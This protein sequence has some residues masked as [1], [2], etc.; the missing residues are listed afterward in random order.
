MVM[1]TSVLQVSCS[2]T[3][4]LDHPLTSVVMDLTVLV[5]YWIANVCLL[6]IFFV[7]HD[8]LIYLHLLFCLLLQ[9]QSFRSRSSDLIR[10]DTP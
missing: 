1:Q 5:T 4:Y 3:Q 2:I 6:Y 7:F 8:Y 9:Q 10:A